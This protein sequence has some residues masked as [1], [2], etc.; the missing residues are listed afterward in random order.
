[1]DVIFVPGEKLESWFAK[2]ESK[3]KAESV[4]QW[5]VLFNRYQVREIKC[6]NIKS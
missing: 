3:G 1:M 6:E 5:I 2:L 4:C